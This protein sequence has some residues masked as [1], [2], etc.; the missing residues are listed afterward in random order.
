MQI[1][2]KGNQVDFEAPVYMEDDYFKEFCKFM[3]EL[4]G[5]KVEIVYVKE[6]ER[7]PFKSGEIK[8]WQPEELLLLLSPL[9]HEELAIKLNRKS[10]SVQMKQADFVP[11]F[12]VW[13]RK[14]GLKLG[15]ITI[16]VV[17]KY[18]EEENDNT[19]RE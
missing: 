9:E 14:K 15:D 7:A 4:T 1:L 3:S 17:K 18:L 11:K 6:K 10:M 8:K 12:N 19:S 16:Q 2:T 5:E 13:V